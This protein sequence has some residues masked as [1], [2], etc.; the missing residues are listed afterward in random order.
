MP[1]AYVFP[2][3]TCS[4]ISAPSCFSHCGIRML[5]F[6]NLF[7]MLGCFQILQKVGPDVC[8]VIFGSDGS[9][10][11]VTE[12]EDGNHN[13][14][15]NTGQNVSGQP[16]DILD[17]T[18]TD[19][20]MDAIPTYESP[21]LIAHEMPNTNNV[22]S[23]YW[24]SVFM[25]TFGSDPSNVQPTELTAGVPLTSS[26][27]TESF[28]PDRSLEAFNQSGNPSTSNE[29]GRYPLIP[30]NITRTQNAATSLPGPAL[31][32][33]STNDLNSYYQNGLSAASQ[34]SPTASNFTATRGTPH[35]VSLISFSSPFLQ[36]S[37]FQF[38]YS[39]LC[40]LHL[41]VV[42]A[43]FERDVDVM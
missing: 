17:L 19:D 35:Q 30:E 10:N 20:A 9:W 14:E 7:G 18:Q 28:T 6:I 8:D 36:H 25:S 37:S 27:L 12:S 2:T 16:A 34:A 13:S 31:Q 3:T 22:D 40:L 1:G 33:N 15:D 26:V 23:D 38:C 39:A 5:I 11:A 41:N 29:H 43:R 4:I 24:A 42:L 32:W 21:S